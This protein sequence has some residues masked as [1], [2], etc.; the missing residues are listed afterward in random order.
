MKIKILNNFLFPPAKFF[1]P[2]SIKW[3]DQDVRQHSASNTPRVCSF[4]S[5]YMPRSVLTESP[6]AA[7][8]QPPP[9]RWSSSPHTYDHVL[10]G[11]VHGVNDR[12]LRG[13]GT[14]R[15]QRKQ[16]AAAALGAPVHP[17]PPSR[18]RC[19]LRG[20]PGCP[21]RDGTPPLGR[22][23]GTPPVPRSPLP[24]RWRR[25][26]P[27]LPP[28]HHGAGPGP[29]RPLLTTAPAPAPLAAPS[30]W[31]PRSRSAPFAPSSPWRRPRPRGAPG[32][33]SARALRR[34]TPVPRTTGPAAPR[35]PATTFRPCRVPGAA[36]AF[37][38]PGEGEGGSG[39]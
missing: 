3:Q 18:V 23:T 32:P 16:R 33:A 31:R 11:R 4:T 39:H 21:G 29:A 22:R 35:P 36:T 17:R 30:P 26:R 12:H 25:T 38:G 15:A 14:E 7:L 13:E 19:T 10:V 24:R 8:S 1:S 37:A 6:R 2:H 5:T 27:R 34:G 9:D 20:A 28:P